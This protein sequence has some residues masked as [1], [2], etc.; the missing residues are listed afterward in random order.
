MPDASGAREF[1]VAT[2]RWSA[3]VWRCTDLLIPGGTEGLK[4]LVVQMRSIPG[5]TSAGR[6]QPVPDACG[7]TP[8]KCH[9]GSGGRLPEAIAAGFTGRLGPAGLASAQMG[10]Y[11][12]ALRCSSP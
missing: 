5:G 2:N 9:P 7:P 10:Y 4:D 1:G 11:H 6:L 12:L 8:V 3:A